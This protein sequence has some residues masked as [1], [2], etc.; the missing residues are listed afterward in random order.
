MIRTTLELITGAILLVL[1]ILFLIYISPSPANLAS[2]II[3]LGAGVL[4]IRK[5]ND[6]RKKAKLQPQPKNA[7]QKQNVKKKN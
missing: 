2:D 3:F 5:A 4:I 1:G 6:D 7:K